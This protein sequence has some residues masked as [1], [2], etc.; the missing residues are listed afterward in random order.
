MSREDSESENESPQFFHYKPNVLRMMERMGYDLTNGPGLKFS[1]GRRTLHWSFV[2]KVKTLDYY[3]RTRRGLGF[4]STPISSP[5]ESEESLYHDYS[6]DTS[7]YESDVSIGNLFGELSV[8]MISTNHL[9]DR[10]EET[11][12][13]D[14]DP[15]I[16]HLNTLWDIRFEQREPPMEDKIT[17]INLGDETNPKP[18]FISE[19]LSPSEKEDLISLVREYIN[20]FAWNYED[21]PGLDPR[22]AM[23]RLNINS[24]VKPVKQQ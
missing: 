20:V 10:D 22:V 3:H 6:S 9:E 11:I 15:W 5:S 21:M 12:Q 4:V 19:S 17:Q 7:S 23:H 14:I 2:P 1:K 18:N 8:N 16:K 24:N 13:S